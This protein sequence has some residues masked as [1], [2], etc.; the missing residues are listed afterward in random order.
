MIPQAG[1][2]E[3]PLFPYLFPSAGHRTGGAIG[4]TERF[5]SVY[6]CSDTNVNVFDIACHPQDPNTLYA[7]TQQALFKSADRGRS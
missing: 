6:A 5:R 2:I 1:R 7:A 4:Y 3:K